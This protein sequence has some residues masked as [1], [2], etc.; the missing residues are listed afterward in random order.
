MATLYMWFTYIIKCK[1]GSF[2]TGITTDLDRRFKE[3]REGH[4]GKYTVSH[5]PLKIIFFERF[6]T[7]SEAS[8][9]EI[10]IK[11]LSHKQKENL[12]K[13]GIS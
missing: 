5:P 3:H 8:K 12:V 4:G 13:L 6:E 1:D 9:R 2:Y 10:E 7:R 11:K